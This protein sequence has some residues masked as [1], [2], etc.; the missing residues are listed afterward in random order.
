M[1]LRSKKKAAG[2]Y[3]E[4]EEITNEISIEQLN[5]VK[6]PLEM[7]QLIQN[8][9][10]LITKQLKKPKSIINLRLDITN[11]TRKFLE[12]QY[13]LTKRFQYIPDFLNEKI[14]FS[15]STSES[16]RYEIIKD[17]FKI[18][19]ANQKTLKFKENNKEI[20]IIYGAQIVIE[21]RKNRVVTMNE[22]MRNMLNNL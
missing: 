17:T 11:K 22:S 20:K 14:I 19:F 1:E 3:A 9:S 13:K 6:R 5:A 18:K 15:L 7:N 10:F 16:I 21:L 4:Y 2:Y 12:K 8:I